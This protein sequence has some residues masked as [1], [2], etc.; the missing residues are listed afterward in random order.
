MLGGE[1]FR[2]S[3]LRILAS[4][5]LGNWFVFLWAVVFSRLKKVYAV[6]KIGCCGVSFQNT[7]RFCL[8]L[9]CLHL[10]LTRCSL[11]S[12]R[13]SPSFPGRLQVMRA[14]LPS[15]RQPGFLTEVFVSPSEW[16]SAP[17][18]CADICVCVPP[19]PLPVCPGNNWSPPHT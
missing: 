18:A 12:L 6:P 15:P 10:F 7:V 4:S 2:A 14:L 1:N 9:F 16:P 3:A 17:C 5:S 11:A 8:H 13:S 19:D